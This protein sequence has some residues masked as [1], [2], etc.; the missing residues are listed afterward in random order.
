[1]YDFDGVSVPELF[2]AIDRALCECGIALGDNDLIAFDRNFVVIQRAL[3]ACRRKIVE[4]CV[5]NEQE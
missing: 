4:N 5:D 1:M 3:V 2:A